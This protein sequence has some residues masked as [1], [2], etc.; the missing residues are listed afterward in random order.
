[1]QYWRFVIVRRRAEGMN[2]MH[3]CRKCQD[4]LASW[5]REWMDVQCTVYDIDELD[6][7]A[8]NNSLIQL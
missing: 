7:P 3:W 2:W 4:T 8:T 1:M 6:Y 5:T